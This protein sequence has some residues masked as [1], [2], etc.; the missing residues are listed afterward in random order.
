MTTLLLVCAILLLCNRAPVASAAS[1]AQV[2]SEG[3]D[4]VFATGDEGEGTMLLDEIDVKQALLGLPAF[5]QEYQTIVQEARDLIAE[6]E[7]LARESQ[8][9]DVC[10]NGCA[11]M[12]M[13][14]C[15]YNMDGVSCA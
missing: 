3:R 12:L 11:L 2:V 10:T 9:K 13:S 1:N 5:Y 6:S 15:L 14:A 8:A 4:V 7:Q